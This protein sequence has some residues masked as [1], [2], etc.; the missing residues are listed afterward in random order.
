MLEFFEKNFLH[1][2]L[3]RHNVFGQRNGAPVVVV[4][5]GVIAHHDWLLGSNDSFSAAEGSRF[6]GQNAP[7]GR[8]RAKKKVG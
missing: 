2:L 3:R 4:V 7:A 5:D 8:F 1:A 6:S